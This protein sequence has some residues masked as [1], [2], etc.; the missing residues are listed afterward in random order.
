MRLS[1]GFT[2]VELTI[3][4]SVITILSI[5]VL[6]FFAT[7]LRQF[8]IANER[9]DLLNEAQITLESI[10]EDIRLSAVADEH[11]RWE[12]ENAPVAGDM[13]SWESDSNTLILATAALDSD[14]YILFSDPSQYISWKDNHIYYL[15]GD[16]LYRRTLA[17]PVEGN[18]A[19]TTCPAEVANNDC[20]ADKVMLNSKV[21]KFIVRYFDGDNNE[22]SP[23][24]ARSIELEIG[25]SRRAY[26]QTISAEHKTRMVFRN[27]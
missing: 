13:F 22:V 8:A 7:N 10:N 27:D 16:V 20:P 2:T 1:R 26:G 4:I 19:R 9:A 17:A 6:V 5:T 14:G 23:T 12:D 18:V 15:N 3:A 25:I 24:D 11:N 21:D